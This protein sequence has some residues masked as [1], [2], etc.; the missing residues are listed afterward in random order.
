MKSRGLQDWVENRAASVAFLTAVVCVVLRGVQFWSGGALNLAQLLGAHGIAAFDIITGLGIA[1]GS[2]LLASIFG[3]QFLRSGAEAR[4]ASGR[5]GLKRAEREALVAEFRFRARLSLL[6]MVVGILAS[7]GA[8]FSFLQATTKASG[9]GQD[10][11]ELAI[12]GTLVLILTAL[13]VFFQPPDRSAEMATE[14]AQ[15]M[16][17]RILEAAAGRITK[18][19]H[20][21]Q[22]VRLLAGSLGKAEREKFLAALAPQATALDPL[23][24]TADL[25]LWLD[26]ADNP[27]LKRQ[28]TRRLSKL[29]ETGLITKNEKGQYIFPRS[30]AAIEFS[31]D[32]V[33]MRKG[34]PRISSV[35]SRE[36]QE[37]RSQ[38]YQESA[39]SQTEAGQEAGENAFQSA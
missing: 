24:T 34:S 30:L 9:I 25:Y 4:E 15:T 10:I 1:L 22:D 20:S 23:W 5:S 7:A 35:P 8:G 13:G 14:H 11:A 17:T 6:F 2:E 31:G 38:V 26:I 27:S 33:S 3:R 32:F 19:L 12:T 28:V 16:R 36:Y 29:A 21:P 39:G 18:G 37:R